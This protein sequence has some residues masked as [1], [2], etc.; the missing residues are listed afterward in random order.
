MFQ[1]LLLY[2]HFIYIYISI[3]GVTLLFNFYNDYKLIHKNKKKVYDPI[4]KNSTT[5]LKKPAFE[6]T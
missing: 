1:K 3:R 4:W 5:Y 2:L 6:S